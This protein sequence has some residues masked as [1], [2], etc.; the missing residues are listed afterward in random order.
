MSFGIF[1]ISLQKQKQIIELWNR[2]NNRQNCISASNSIVQSVINE[3]PLDGGLDFQYLKTTIENFNKILTTGYE[4]NFAD[5]GG[6]LTSVIGF[7]NVGLADEISSGTNTT[8]DMIL[9]KI[10]KFFNIPILP[11][12]G[13]KTK[14]HK[15]IIEK[16]KTNIDLPSLSERCANL[17]I[18]FV[19][20]ATLAR[21]L[22]RFY[23]N[24]WEYGSAS[25]VADGIGLISQ[26]PV[27]SE[28][29][30]MVFECIFDNC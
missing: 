12:I 17:A 2:I 16:L 22:A 1:F 5:L 7:T 14:K 26:I 10:T 23:T 20:Y 27:F 6:L 19:V 25:N 24:Q 30:D 4:G 9:K 21:Y 11:F 28:N 3:I 15:T 29:M 8:N 13:N 18:K